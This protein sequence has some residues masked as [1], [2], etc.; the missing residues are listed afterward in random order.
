MYCIYL[1]TAEG[2][3]TIYRADTYPDFC[4]MQAAYQQIVLWDVCIHKD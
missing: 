4:A 2:W 3:C 1:A